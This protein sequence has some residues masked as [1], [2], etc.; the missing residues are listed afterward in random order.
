MGSQL[1]LQVSFGVSGYLGLFGIFGLL[2]ALAYG[3]RYLLLGLEALSL[4]VYTLNSTGV[5]DARSGCRASGFI[6]L[7]G[8][9]LQFRVWGLGFMSQFRV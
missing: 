9:M 5:Q 1:Q 2:V 8:L 3:L 6:G 4:P 7:I